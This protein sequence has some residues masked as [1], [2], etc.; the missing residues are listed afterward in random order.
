[1]QE[2]PGRELRIA[3]V[4]DEALMRGFME[5]LVNST[6]GMHITHSVA[7]QSDG[8][9]RIRPGSVDVAVV[10]IDLEDGNGVSLALILQQRDPALRILLLSSHNMLALVR[11]V[12]DKATNQW[13]YLSKRSFLDPDEVRRALAAIAAGRVVIDPWLVNRSE[14]RA[15]SPLADLSSSQL[16]VLRLIAQGYSNTT[17]AERL[18]IT[19]KTVE[20][21]LTAI[22]RTLHVSAEANNRV[23][24]V[25]AFLQHTT[26][27]PVER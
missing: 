27:A 10:D 4:E 15:D 24:A 23:A 18:G 13:S 20:A 5:E 16:A 1:M 26:R 11:S 12:R 7:G 14:P 25:L 8:R 6:P 17:V 2:T 9:D 3:L 21:H 22:Y 19:L